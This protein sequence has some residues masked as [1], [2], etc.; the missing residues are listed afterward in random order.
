MPNN[1][2]IISPYVD[3]HTHKAYSNNEHIVGVQSFMIG[4]APAPEYQGMFS[5]GIHPWQ[6]LAVDPNVLKP[7]FLEAIEKLQPHAIGEAGIDLSISA[8]LNKQRNLFIF[9]AAEAEKRQL[10]LIIHAVRSYSEL[11]GIRKKHRFSGR[12]IVHGYRG[13]SQTCRSLWEA[14]LFVSF[15]AA[16]MY[17][18]TSLEDAFDDCPLN[19]LFLETDTVQSPTI[20]TLYARAASIKQ[21]S[22]DELRNTIF[23]NFAGCFRIP[24]TEE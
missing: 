21:I 19:Q 4:E 23:A 22:E 3:V 6:L 7:F 15:G 9:Q 13:N 14:G 1:Q 20:Q 16:L 18:A 5:T 24:F 10:P 2:Q 11:L 8:N 17:T 12:W